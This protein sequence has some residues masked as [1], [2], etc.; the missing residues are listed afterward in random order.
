M[1]FSTIRDQIKTILA[2][3][4][5]IGV[6][7]NRRR[8]TIDFDQM[9]SLYGKSETVNG[10]SLVR[11]NGWTIHRVATPEGRD[12]VGE[13]VRQYQFLIEGYY[14]FDDRDDADPDAVSPSQI[15][16]D[17]LIEAICD[18]FRPA[19]TLN[20]TAFTFEPIQVET[21]EERMFAGILCH[22]ARL[23][24]AAVEAVPV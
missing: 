14:S 7:H 20:D 10:Q 23:R 22:Y 18:A 4:A 13:T 21:V 11:I 24:L 12:T 2:G 1:P 3:V 9:K 6:V 5:G 17:T 8:W 16:L 15:L 19:P